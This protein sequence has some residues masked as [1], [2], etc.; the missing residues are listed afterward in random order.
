MPNL[1]CI[2]EYNLI[3]LLV[4]I[5][6]LMYYFFIIIT[7]KKYIYIFSKLSNK[8]NVTYEYCMCSLRD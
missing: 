5:D 7:L 3:E 8:K 6:Y 2:N 4:Y 1:T